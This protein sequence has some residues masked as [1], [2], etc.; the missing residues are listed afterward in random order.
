MKETK[1]FFDNNR[2]NRGYSRVSNSRQSD[3]SL[4]RR[5]YQHVLPPIDMMEQYEELNPGTFEKLFDMADKE[6]NHRHSM[7]L[8]TIEKHS[9]A[10]RLGR[11]F[12]LVFVGLVS[13]TTL[14]LVLVES[15]I[16]ASVFA[17]S[18]F[19]CITIISY[20][21]SKSSI[22]KESARNKQYKPKHYR[23]NNLASRQFRK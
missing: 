8:L 23:N 21:Y 14:M 1:K 15:V 4:V 16:S 9:R 6:Q 19:A 2:L 11:M 18:A 17:I 22:H 20:F 13:I 7:D 12:A 10:T 3:A 5:K